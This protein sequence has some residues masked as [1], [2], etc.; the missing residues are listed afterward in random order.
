MERKRGKVATLGNAARRRGVGVR[1][2]GEQPREPG[3]K[4]R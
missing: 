4:R 3:Y 1:E 2:A